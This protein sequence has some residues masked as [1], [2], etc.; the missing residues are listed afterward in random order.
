MAIYHATAKV[1][2]RSAGKSATAAAAYRAGDRIADER[3]GVV[4]DYS[5][6]GGVDH[7]EI[8]V[9]ANAPRW[10]QDRET[11]WNMVELGEKRKDSQL[12]R[13]FQVALPIE[14]SHQEKIDLAKSFVTDT[15]VNRGMVADLNIHHID[16]QN[17]HAHIM[18][19]MRDIE[20]GVFGSKNRAWNDKELLQSW[21]EAWEIKA[22]EALELAGR[23]ERIDHRTLEEQGIERVPQVHLG[24]K[25]A[26]MEERGVQTD[27][28]TIWNA[29]DQD[30]ARIAAN[31]EFIQRLSPNDDRVESLRDDT[32]AILAQWKQW[33][34][35]REREELSRTYQGGENTRRFGSSHRALSPELE[36]ALRGWRGIGAVHQSEPRDDRAEERRDAPVARAFEFDF[37]T[38]EERH[39]TIRSEHPAEHSRGEVVLDSTNVA[40]NDLDYAGAYSR[41]LALSG[42]SNHQLR[43]KDGA[44]YLAGQ[45]AMKDRTRIAVDNQLE[46]MGGNA[47]TVGI[48]SEKGMMLR[49]WDREEVA[50]SIGFL[51]SQNAMG[52]DI[53]IRP[54]AENQS[55]GLILMDDLSRATVD[56]LKE[57]GYQPAAVVE[58]SPQNFQAWIRVSESK[59]RADVATAIAKGMA[60][61]FGA[62]MNSADYKHF[63]R[64][65]GFTNTKD[66]YTDERGYQPFVKLHEHGGA[67]ASRAEAL[68]ERGEELA[69]ETKRQQRIETINL[70]NKDRSYAK[71]SVERDFS[72]LYA[73]NHHR[74]K[75]NQADTSRVDW[76]TVK[77]LLKMGHDPEN[78]KQAL[79]ER[80]PDIATRKDGHVQDYVDRTIENALKEPDVKQSLF[81]LER[82]R[83]LGLER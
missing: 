48:R 65:A 13:E 60:K 49:D 73:E 47:F 14:L 5:R 45:D 18:L 34:E 24:R 30:N 10:M 54:N 25:V 27:R 46:A 39:R 63:G 81:E 2:G 17:P 29:I 44:D 4:H 70:I 75:E 28:G 53:Y 33:R 59:V 68:V 76:A 3:T 83:D 9:P 16:G 69:G 61:A 8:I 35:G 64:L 43:G 62:D 12:A 15:F 57:R 78:V 11:L 56:E 31:D 41:I 19:T 50:N 55:A 51:K 37:G 74:L 71:N 72:R 7:S 66:Q 77:D 80:S 6:K 40:H 23:T 67:I 38:E 21:R 20:D 79:F 42:H 58:T 52:A 22:N 36:H 26:E 32:L 82:S 1:I